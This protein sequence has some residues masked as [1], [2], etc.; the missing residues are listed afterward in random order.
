[1]IDEL[2]DLSGLPFAQCCAVLLRYQARHLLCPY[3][4]RCAQWKLR[5]VIADWVA[6]PDKVREKAGIAKPEAAQPENNGAITN[7]KLAQLRC[8]VNRAV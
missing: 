5:D 2:A 7:W 1:M 6:S 3:Y 8:C 4:I